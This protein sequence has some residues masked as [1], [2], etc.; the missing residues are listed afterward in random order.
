MFNLHGK[1]S[2]M[3]LAMCVRRS[4][5]G[6]TV[7]ESYCEQQSNF[8]KNSYNQWLSALTCFFNPLGV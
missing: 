6:P 8:Q 2:F 7:R 1:L 4:S 3:S 5:D